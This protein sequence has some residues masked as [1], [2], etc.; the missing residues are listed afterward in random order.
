M[1]P[2]IGGRAFDTDWVLEEVIGRRVE[3]VILSRWYRV[4]LWDHD[5]TMCG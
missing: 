3:A 4:E 1:V 5:R 2:L